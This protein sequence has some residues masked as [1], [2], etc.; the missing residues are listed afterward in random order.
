MKTEKPSKA[1]VLVGGEGTRLRPLT[2]T[3]TKAMVPVLKVPFIQHVIHHLNKHNVTD[4]VLAMGYKPDSIKNHFEKAGNIT[5][6]LIYSIEESPL[7]TAGAVKNAAPYIGKNET[8]FILNG[9]IFTDLNLTEM[10]NF[11]RTK[12]ASVTI[13]LTPVDDPTQFGVVELDD[14]QLVTRFIEKPRRDE[15]TSNLINAGVYILESEILERIPHGK[16]FMFEHDVFPQ[17][18]AEGVPVYAYTTNAYWID[19][20]T[21][22][23]YLRLNHELLLGRC[24]LEN[25]L[26]EKNTNKSHHQAEITGPVLI[27]EGCTIGKGVQMKGPS[28]IG[29]KCSIGDYAVIEKTILWSKVQVGEHATLKNCIITSDV[30]IESNTHIEN[31][32]IGQDTDSNQLIVVKSGA[33]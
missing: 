22:E 29:S 30:P 5:A 24:Q 11:H 13:A 9:D 26:T 32:V 19:M 14:Q 6:R 17:L 1:V 3:T 20:G 28:V 16:R 15:V 7:G 25:Q 8:L 21:P 12:K 10:F 4:I 2:Y 31:A 23:K 33:R 27:D 18:I